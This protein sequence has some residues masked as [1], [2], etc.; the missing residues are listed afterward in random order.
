MRS[1]TSMIVC[2]LDG[3]DIGHRGQIKNGC[4]NNVSGSCLYNRMSVRNTVDMDI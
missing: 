2:V 1:C 4:T 3:F